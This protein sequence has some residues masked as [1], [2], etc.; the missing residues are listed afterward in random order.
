MDHKQALNI[1]IKI[2]EKYS[3]AAEEKEAIMTAIGILSWTTLSESRLKA[4]KAKKEKRRS[5][6]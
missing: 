5:N 2:L 3:F 6:N 1:L 4:I